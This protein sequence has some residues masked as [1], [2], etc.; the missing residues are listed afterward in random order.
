MQG[1]I[2]VPARNLELILIQELLMRTRHVQTSFFLPSN[3]AENLVALAVL[4][5]ASQRV[6][7]W[8][9]QRRIAY[10]NELPLLESADAESKFRAVK[11][12]FAGTGLGYSDVFCND[13][14]HT[15]ISKRRRFHKYCS[16]C[17]K[18]QETAGAQTT[19]LPDLVSSIPTC[20]FW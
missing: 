8:K 18:V 1:N 16:A 4:E 3:H 5:W 10:S 13:I 6:R 19:G 7:I 9:Q 2:E 11:F 15:G 14:V 17:L 12:Q 20:P